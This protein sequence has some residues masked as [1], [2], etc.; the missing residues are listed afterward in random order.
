MGDINQLLFIKKNI[1]KIKG[2]IL[3]VCNKNYETVPIFLLITVSMIGRK[4][5][6]L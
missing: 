5:Y 3:E 1:D 2:P 6:D 4:E